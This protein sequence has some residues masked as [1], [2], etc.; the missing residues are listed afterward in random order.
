[1]QEMVALIRVR[2]KKKSQEKNS[3]AGQESNWP[4]L[5]EQVRGLL[6]DCI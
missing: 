6:L 5:E 2:N 3:V 1:M 4:K